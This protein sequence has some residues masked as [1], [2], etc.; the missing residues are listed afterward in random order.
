MLEMR[1]IRCDSK[2]KTD[3]HSEDKIDEYIYDLNIETYIV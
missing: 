2:T 3:C 1:V